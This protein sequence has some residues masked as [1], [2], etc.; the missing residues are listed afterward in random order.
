MTHTSREAWLQAGSRA[1]TPIFKKAGG[2]VPGKVRFSVG[3]PSTGRKGKRIGECWQDSA[4]EDAHYEIFIRP[5]L[6]EPVFILGVLAHELVHAALPSKSGHGPV[7][8]KLALA[9][10]LTGKMTATLPGEELD[11]KLEQ[12]AAKLGLLPHARLNLTATSED[13]PK[14]QGTRL[15]K[16]ECCVC[17]YTVRVTKKW[18]DVGPPHCPHHGAMDMDG[19]EDD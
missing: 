2:T 15:L 5:D 6:D 17:G 11:A 4:S 9:I 1:L 12:I 3:F 13:A 14:K 10:G 8:K 19:G 7:F 16:A 18:A